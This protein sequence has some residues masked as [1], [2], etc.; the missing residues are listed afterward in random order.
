MKIIRIGNLKVIV[1]L[2]LEIQNQEILLIIILEE[3]RQIMY[4]E[5]K[6][7]YKHLKIVQD[8]NKMIL[9]KI[10][11]IDLPNLFQKIENIMIVIL[12]LKIKMEKIG[13]LKINI[14][15]IQ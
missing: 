3:E 5:I 11:I 2:K 13:L 1:I 8:L 9:M 15:I 12:A 4:I 14:I 10:T 7:H 6:N